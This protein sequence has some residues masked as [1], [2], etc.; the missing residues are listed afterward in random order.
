MN[1]IH[2]NTS[3]INL[4]LYDSSDEEGE[5]TEEKMRDF[6]MK[7]YNLSSVEGSRKLPEELAEISY[8][9]WC[10]SNRASNRINPKVGLTPMEYDPDNIG[11]SPEDAYR[12]YGNRL[13]EGIRNQIRSKIEEQRPQGMPFQSSNTSTQNISSPEQNISSNQNLPGLMPYMLPNPN[14]ENPIEEQQ[15]MNIAENPIQIGVDSEGKSVS[16]GSG[17]QNVPYDESGAFNRM[18]PDL[19]SGNRRIE[20]MNQG[21]SFPDPPNRPYFNPM[22]QQYNPEIPESTFPWGKAAAI[23]GGAA[24]GAGLLGYLMSDK[25]KKK[26]GKR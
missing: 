11:L 19:E 22:N 26:E 1:P 12:H 24:L 10:V 8:G 5:K 16:M 18:W 23:G 2:G 20:E 4:S 17:G 15:N 25:N 6:F 9:L 3:Y 14:M 21:R 7:N 13:P